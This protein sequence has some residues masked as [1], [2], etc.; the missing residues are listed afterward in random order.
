[1]LVLLGSCAPG[2]P[3]ATPTPSPT[4]SPSPAPTMSPE[5]TETGMGDNETGDVSTPEGLEDGVYVGNSGEDDR[6]NFGEIRIT[7]ADEKITEVEFTEYSGENNPKSAENGY[8][9]EEALEAIE[10]LPKQL[11]ETQDV[12]KIDDYTGATG[13][14]EKFRTA[15]KNALSSSPQQGDDTNAT[16]DADENENNTDTGNGDT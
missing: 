13:T 15:A 7:I 2:Q 10:E 6:G 8:E 11:I 9:Y 1:V 14:T 12:D 16:D 4:S 3:K 5:P